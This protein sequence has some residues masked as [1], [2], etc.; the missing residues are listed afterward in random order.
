MLACV[1]RGHDCEEDGGFSRQAR[2]VSDDPTLP[3]QQVLAM[4]EVRRHWSVL[5]AALLPKLHDHND[6]APAH[7]ILQPIEVGWL[8][9]HTLSLA[10]GPKRLWLMCTTVGAQLGCLAD[11]ISLLR[12]SAPGRTTPLIKGCVMPLMPACMRTFMPC[13][14]PP[15]RPAR[16]QLPKELRQL[17]GRLPPAQYE[18]GDGMAF[19]L[20]RPI[21]ASVG[22]LAGMEAAENGA[23]P[24]PFSACRC[25]ILL[26]STVLS[27]HSCH[28]PSHAPA[29]WYPWNVLS[30]ALLTPQGQQTPRPA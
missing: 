27:S 12:H 20:S 26:L 3:P 14:E 18:S 30:L 16:P 19:L 17:N 10:I 13:H 4:P 5:P 21:S 28:V 22:D 24:G 8:G 1:R 15:P 25:R 2:P 7:H 6:G 11:L 29:I 23:Q 9:M